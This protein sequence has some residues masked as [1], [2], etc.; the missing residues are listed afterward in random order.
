MA[1]DV[2]TNTFT[3]QKIV[4]LAERRAGSPGLH[5]NST[6]IEAIDAPAYLELQAILDHLAQNFDWPFR[7]DALTLNVSTRTTIL[8]DDYWNTWFTEAYV[9]H[10]DTGVR[11]PLY[12]LGRA[13]FHSRMSPA[14]VTTGMPTIASIM[15]HR[16]AAALGTPE[17]VLLVDLAPDRTY[18]IELHYNPQAVPLAAITSIPWFPYSQYLI[19]SLLVKLYFNQDDSRAASA[20][21]ERERL[22][23][24]IRRAQSD[25]GQRGQQV[26]YDPLVYRQPLRLS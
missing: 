16:G 26:Q 21:A 5:L 24:E 25:A 19:E 23:M 12:I 8:P 1:L 9:I 22:W 13:E 2:F 18:P 11:T 20:A 17:G 15:K 4:T 10:P 3:A 14:N 6:P 7:D